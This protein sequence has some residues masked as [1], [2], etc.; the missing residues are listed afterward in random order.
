MIRVPA[1]SDGAEP[2]IVAPLRTVVDRYSN[3]RAVVWIAVCVTALWRF[4][5]CLFSVF[6]S[7]STDALGALHLDVGGRR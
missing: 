2:E 1:S 5:L 7:E 3:V 4:V 6:R